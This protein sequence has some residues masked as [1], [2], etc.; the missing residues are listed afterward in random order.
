MGGLCSKSTKS[1]KV[2]AKKKEHYDNHKSGVG[3]GNKNNHKH[4]T[5]DLTSAKEGIDKKKEEE[6]AV[7]AAIASGTSAEDFYDGIPRYADSFSHK[8]RSVRSRQ[9]AVAKVGC[10]I[11]DYTPFFFLFYSIWIICSISEFRYV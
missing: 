4:T 6:E 7:A 10:L 2:F 1:D 5:S 9:A 8:S 3:G 11:Y